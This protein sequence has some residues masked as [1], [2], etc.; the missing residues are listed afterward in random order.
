M[1]VRP[2]RTRPAATTRQAG[3]TSRER[4]AVPDRR[5]ARCSCREAGCAPATSRWRSAAAKDVAGREFGS[6]PT[7]SLPARVHLDR[8]ARCGER[9]GQDRDRRQDSTEPG[10]V[11][12]MPSALS[13][14]KIASSGATSAGRD[15]RVRT[16]RRAGGRSGRSPRARRRRARRRRPRRRRAMRTGRP[17]RG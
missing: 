14:L 12:P 7:V 15:R 16:A 17:R 4:C 10:R 6:P 2:R 9:A 8:P 3:R 1:P 13:A 5:R 11:A